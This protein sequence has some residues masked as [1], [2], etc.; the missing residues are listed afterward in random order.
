SVHAPFSLFLIQSPPPLSGFI[1]YSP[2][3][4]YSITPSLFIGSPILTSSSN[5]HSIP[6]KSIT[7]FSSNNSPHIFSIA[8]SLP[9]SPSFITSNNSSNSS[10]SLKTS[11][12]GISIHTSKMES[13]N[14]AISL[15]SKSNS[16]LVSLYIESSAYALVSSINVWQ[17]TSTFLYF[18][19]YLSISSLL[20]SSSFNHDNH[21][22]TSPSLPLYIIGYPI[23]SPSISL[24]PSVSFV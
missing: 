16:S 19:I 3:I 1:K 21:T 24:N 17:L 20:I 2:S 7:G 22:V 10:F 11:S 9:S 23:L 15:S 13:L 14:K 4:S 5:T 12:I 18:S 8:S 6:F